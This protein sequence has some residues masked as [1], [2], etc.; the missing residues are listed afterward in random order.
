MERYGAGMLYHL[1]ELIQMYLLDLEVVLFEIQRINY[2]LNY[3]V[4][5]NDNI[6]ALSSHQLKK[7]VPDITSPVQEAMA[8]DITKRSQPWF[9]CK[10]VLYEQQFCIGNSLN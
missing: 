9:V 2:K 4:D 5:I 6:L 1:P 8:W 3:V 10:V 7:A